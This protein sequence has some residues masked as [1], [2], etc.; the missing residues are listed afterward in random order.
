MR[1]L[2]LA[3]AAGLLAGCAMT[4]GLVPGL[5]GK[6][7]YEAHFQDS[8]TTFDVSISAPA[9]VDIS[10]IA[11]MDYEWFESGAGH[12]MVNSDAGLS[13]QGQAELLSHVAELTAVMVPAIADSIVG[14]I[15]DMISSGLLRPMPKIEPLEATP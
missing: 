6:T 15:T 12:V 9:G 2:S 3:L 5:G 14:A 4:P 8:D 1:I 10:N 13:T 11:S 7:N